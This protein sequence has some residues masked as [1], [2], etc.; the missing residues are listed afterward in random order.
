MV[1]VCFQ[2]EDG[3]RDLVRSHGLGDVYKGQC[4]FPPKR[5]PCMGSPTPMWLTPHPWRMWP[6]R[7]S[8]CLLYTSD[9]DDELLRVDL[10]GR[11]NIKKNNNNNNNNN[12]ST[13]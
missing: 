7:C 10:G 3:I 12:C 4:L 8:I 6:A 2:A 13:C 1:G 9:A 5:R 11:R